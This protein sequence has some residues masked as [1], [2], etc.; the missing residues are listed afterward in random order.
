MGL[1][2]DNY[3]QDPMSTLV[4]VTTRR[5]EEQKKPKSSQSHCRA[6]AASSASRARWALSLT[7]FRVSPLFCFFWAASCAWSFPPGLFEAFARAYCFAI[8]IHA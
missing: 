3:R 6:L 5:N 7:S 1:V 8:R 4:L 2:D